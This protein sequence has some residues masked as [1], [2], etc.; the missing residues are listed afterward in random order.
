MSYTITVENKIQLGFIRRVLTVYVM[1]KLGQ[2]KNAFNEVFQYTE[3]L[4]VLPPETRAISTLIKILPDSRLSIHN[5]SITEGT[6]ICWDMAQVI[7]HQEYLDMSEKDKKL[8]P[9]GKAIHKTSKL[10]LIECK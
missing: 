8:K 10:P 7:R 1:L 2:W 3:G 9:Y 5:K 4:E 6:R